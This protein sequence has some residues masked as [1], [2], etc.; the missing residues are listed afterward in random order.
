MISTTTKTFNKNKISATKSSARRCLF[1]RLDH[2][3]INESLERELRL[4]DAQ[5][6]EKWEFDF[7]KEQPLSGGRFAWSPVDCKSEYVPGP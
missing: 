5:L 2:K 7:S 1:G 4:I 3:V 6:E